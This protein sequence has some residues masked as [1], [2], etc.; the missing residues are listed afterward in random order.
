MREDPQTN[1]RP[2]QRVGWCVKT[3]HKI[4]VRWVSQL[5]W[6]NKFTHVKPIVKLGDNAFDATLVL[7]VIVER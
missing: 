6:V 1:F 3:D 4:V 2:T 5:H 7:V